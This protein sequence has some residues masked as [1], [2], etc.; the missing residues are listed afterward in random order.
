MT[1]SDPNAV[2]LSHQ[3]LR[4][5]EDVVVWPARERGEL[6]Y[7][8]EI[9][10]EHKFFRVGYEEY[11]F[12]SLLD[13]NTTVPQ[14][15]GLAAAKL[16]NRAPSERQAASIQRWLLTNKLAYLP[17]D[18]APIRGLPTQRTGST[19]KWLLTKIN[20]FW[21]KLPLINSTRGSSA[22]QLV[23]SIVNPICWLLSPLAV[24]IGLVA[25]VAG[26]LILAAN[27]DS[28]SASATEVFQP[29]QLALAPGVLGRVENRPRAGPR[30]G[31]PSSGW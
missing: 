1:R 5:A 27:W 25:I 21:M 8:L 2:D 20:P 12:I 29:Q 16:G 23:A 26:L 14:A 13:G 18:A 11:V 24:I 31:L 28:F 17:N 19:A 4:L 10:S 22:S 15:C 7:R 9:P 3:R 6:I 30:R